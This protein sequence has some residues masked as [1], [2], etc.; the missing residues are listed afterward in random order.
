LNSLHSV[1]SLYS[2]LCFCFCLYWLPCWCIFRY[3]LT[4]LGFCFCP[5]GYLLYFIFYILLFLSFYD[6]WF[7]FLYGY[8]FAFFVFEVT[9]LGGHFTRPY[10]SVFVLIGYLVGV[11]SGMR[12]ARFVF[13][14]FSMLYFLLYF[15]LL[16]LFLFFYDSLFYLFIYFVCC[17]THCTR[18]SLYSPYASV[19]SL[20][21]TFLAYLLVWVERC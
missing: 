8:I 4:A 21:V 9:A 14:A 18:W 19:L 20:L 2:P 3:E 12:D 11:S 16:Y 1:W 6:I 15:I 7:L 17:W 10:A 13:R 5:Y